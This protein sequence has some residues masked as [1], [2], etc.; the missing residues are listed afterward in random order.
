[1]EHHKVMELHQAPHFGEFT[2]TYKG[3]E[4][5]VPVALNTVAR[6]KPASFWDWLLFKYP[7]DLTIKLT[8]EH[9]IEEQSI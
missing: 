2:F 7:F 1:M 5:Y 9:L 8:V 6:Y 4:I 3:A